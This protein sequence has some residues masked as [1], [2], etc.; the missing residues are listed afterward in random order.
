MELILVRHAESIWN[1]EERWQGQSDI[2]LSE[3]GVREAETLGKRCADMEIDAII[4][5]VLVRARETAEAVVRAR[6]KGTLEL[7]AGL[8]E[9]NLGAWCGLPHAE[10]MQHFPDELAALAQGAEMRIGGDGESLPIFSARVHQAL[11]EVCAKHSG[12]KRLMIVMHGGCIRV[13]LF[14]L[15]GLKGRMRPLEG[16]QNT[17]LTTFTGV[18]PGQ[19]FG[20]LK[21]YND[22]LHVST[23]Q[24]EFVLG[25]EGRART[26]DLLEL[27]ESVPLI[28]PPKTSRTVLNVRSRRLVRYAVGA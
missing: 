11:H 8:R 20:A 28:T 17:S 22:M 21:T 25:E 24:S 9:M 1:A 18:V 14:S 7:H 6:G 5:S 4:S 23:D 15:L 3:R 16:A 26:I 13:V 27:A 2:Q 19:S 12:A 10:V